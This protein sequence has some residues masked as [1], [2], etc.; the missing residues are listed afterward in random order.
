[1]TDTINT[2]Q[3]FY[4]NVS[5]YNDLKEPQQATYGLKYNKP[6]ISKIENYKV[7]VERL[8][9]STSLIPIADLTNKTLNFTIKKLSVGNPTQTRN[10]M[11]FYTSSSSTGDKLLRNYSDLCRAF[12]LAIKDALTA[13]GLGS[14]P[15]VGV[16][17]RYD[18]QISGIIVLYEEDYPPDVASRPYDIIMSEDVYNL[19]GIGFPYIYNPADITYTFNAFSE[20]TDYMLEPVN[21]A[22]VQEYYYKVLP[23]DTNMYNWHDTDKIVLTTSLPV[24][25]E[26]VSSSKFGSQESNAPM[27]ILTDFHFEQNIDRHGVLYNSQGKGR[28]INLV[29]SDKLTDFEISLMYAKKDGTTKPVYIK[30]GAHFEIKLKFERNTAM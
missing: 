21:V 20:N 15:H 18:S 9:V 6:L 16:R 12:N 5:C 8:Y 10:I 11:N 4:A 23:E 2:E 17:F 22:G 29:G 24:F 14:T 19:F 3:V 13:L 25:S 28:V 30:A 27:S 7:S 26:I 1:M